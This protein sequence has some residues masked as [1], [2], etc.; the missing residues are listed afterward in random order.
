MKFVAQG[1]I[2]KIS[3][4]KVFYCLNYVHITWKKSTYLN[5]IEM[6]ETLREGR[7]EERKERSNKQGRNR[8][9]GKGGR[10]I[11]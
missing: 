1:L 5:R 4:V 10:K 7:K 3:L 6:N 2:F 9:E 11:P 8:G